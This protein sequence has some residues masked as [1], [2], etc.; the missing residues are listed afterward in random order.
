M[1]GF[2]SN[3]FSRARIRSSN[4]PRY[5]VPATMA[6][7]SRLTTRLLKST[8][9]VLCLAISCANP[10]TMALLPTP[11]SPINIG[12]FFFRRPRISMTRR[13]S[14]SLPTTGSSFPSLAACVKSV[15][16]LSRIGVL[17]FPFLDCVAVDG[18]ALL[19]L[20]PVCCPLDSNS[21]SSSSS[22][23]SSLLL[24]GFA[25]RRK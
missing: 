14:L 1:S 16:K 12:L 2:C 15:E 6:V 23:K 25:I 18:A 10:S 20:E 22:G 24:V 13:I 7:M 3:S 8:G 17:P 5:F 4:C 9:D 21:A 11:G 19:W